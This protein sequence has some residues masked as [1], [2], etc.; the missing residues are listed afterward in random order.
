[1]TRTVRVKLHKYHTDELCRTTVTGKPCLIVLEWFCTNHFFNI[2]IYL[3]SI[4]RNC[5]HFVYQAVP[6]PGEWTECGGREWRMFPENMTW[7]NAERICQ[8]YGGHLAYW[9]DNQS[10]TTCAKKVLQTCFRNGPQIAVAYVGIRDIFNLTDYPWVKSNS[11]RN[12]TLTGS[13]LCSTFSEDL[14]VGV[15][16]C[17]VEYPFICERPLG[18]Y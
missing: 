11:M 4:L 8:S 7:S 5:D 18:R 12:L 16:N 9:E 13:R 6:A 17:S 10:R 15:S 3:F 14:L 1:M 2:F